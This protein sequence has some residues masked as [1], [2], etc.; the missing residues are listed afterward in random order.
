M[1]GYEWKSTLAPM[2][3][4]YLEVKHMAGLKYT[5]QERCLQ[6]FDHFYYYSGYD[7]VSFTKDAITPFLY[8]QD[9]A[10]STWCRKET[11]IADFARFL[12]ERG[13][14][15]YVPASTNEWPK[16]AHIP[17][18]YTKDERIRFLRAVDTYP[19]GH[20][21]HRD[22]S[23]PLLFRI[24]IGTGCRLSEALSL[25][26]GD[27]QRI[28]GSVTIRHSKNGTSRTI[29]ICSSLQE[30]MCSYIEYIHEDEKEN[31]LLFPGIK[32]DH[33]LDKSTIYRR[34]RDYLLMAD[35]PHTIN[36]PRIHDW[37]HTAAVENLRRWS[38]QGK[39]LTRLLPYLS[40]FMGHADFRAT[41]YY[42]RLTAEVY[43]HLVE[44]MEDACWN[45]IPEGGYCN[46]E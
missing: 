18:I 31:S 20:G 34:F 1:N 22:R 40:A 32:E 16:S 30:R 35:I 25:R 39:D 6:H 38:E 8:N 43:P 24:L 27:Y 33:P 17:H 23:D 14:M 13:F 10:L 11:L 36:G 44:K 4:R 9:E 3:A 42:L 21:L 46:E 26:T 45:I 41:Q 28:T 5:R 19:A 2:I 37:R 15:A 7:A 12:N 29:P